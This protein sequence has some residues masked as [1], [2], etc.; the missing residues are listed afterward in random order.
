MNDFLNNIE[1]FDSGSNYKFGDKM[2]KNKTPR[3]LFDLSHLSTM[4]IKN[5]GYMVPTVQLQVY[6]YLQELCQ[7]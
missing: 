2:I 1:G 3:S 7:K 5:C 6:E 4:T